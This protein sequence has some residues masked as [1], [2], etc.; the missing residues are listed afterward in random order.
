GSH[1]AW[2]G[3][4]T[5]EV[6][7]KA[8]ASCRRQA[9]GVTGAGGRW[10]CLRHRPRERTPTAPCAIIP[11]TGANRGGLIRPGVEPILPT[12][13]IFYPPTLEQGPLLLRFRPF[14]VHFGNKTRQL[15]GFAAALP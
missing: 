7:A 13:A 8:P 15:T 12:G 2:H 14:L 3:R 5:P 4:R 11:E 6:G 10:P 9:F 1:P